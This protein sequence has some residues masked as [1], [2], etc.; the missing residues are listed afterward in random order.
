MRVCRPGFCEDH[1]FG[2]FSFSALQNQLQQ[3]MDFKMQAFM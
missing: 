1:A 2:K 3:Q